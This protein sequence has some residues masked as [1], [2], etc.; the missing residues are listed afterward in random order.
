MTDFK[1]INR[2][3]VWM[4]TAGTI[5]GILVVSVA[6]NVLFPRWAVQQSLRLRRNTAWQRHATPCGWC[7]MAAGTGP[8]GREARQPNHSSYLCLKWNS[9]GESWDTLFSRVYWLA[10]TCG[11]SLNVRTLLRFGQPGP[12]ETCMARC[13]ILASAYGDSHW[14]VIRDYGNQDFVGWDEIPIPS[15]VRYAHR[16]L[17]AWVAHVY[18]TTNLRYW[19]IDDVV[20]K[21]PQHWPLFLTDLALVQ[22][23]DPLPNQVV[24][25]STSISATVMVQNRGDELEPGTVWALLDGVEV[26]AQRVDF[27]A[28]GHVPVKFEVGREADEDVLLREHQRWRTPYK[29]SPE[30][31][32]RPGRHTLTF[33]VQMR[34]GG[35]QVPENDTLRVP[36]T[37]AGEF[38]QPVPGEYPVPRNT[39]RGGFVVAGDNRGTIYV[40]NPGRLDEAGM[41]F[42]TLFMA[43]T[44][45]SGTWTSLPR[46]EPYLQAMLYERP[47]LGGATV[48]GDSLFFCQLNDSGPLMKYDIAAKRWD[49]TSYPTIPARRLGIKTD[50]AGGVCWDGADGL[51]VLAHSSFYRYSISKDTWSIIS[52]H[53]GSGSSLGPGDTCGNAGEV[54]FLDD[55]LYALT[56]DRSLIRYHVRANAWNRPVRLPGKGRIHMCRLA[57]DPVAQRVYILADCGAT[58]K[59]QFLAFSPDQDSWILD[60]PQPEWISQGYTLLPVSALTR[61][62]RYLVLARAKDNQMYM[63]N[64]PIPESRQQDIGPIFR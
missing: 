43:C 30:V 55:C 47:T 5:A 44:L 2:N 10:D 35:D 46:F 34:F 23:L 3:P 37:V 26:G 39:V 58:G 36:F 12:G 13:Q 9:N 27:P 51:Y 52:W 42:M 61:A 64:L 49:V 63:F 57:A 60:L 18:D 53:P 11:E 59:A 48:V 20:V 17:F 32:L 41:P 22:S 40:R 62:G 54:A 4:W 6:L 31:R 1:Q 29:S 8:W 21:H 24:P 25:P 16:V 14:V 7:H 56:V 15:P 28:F 45:P 50:L 33:L 38:W 19:C